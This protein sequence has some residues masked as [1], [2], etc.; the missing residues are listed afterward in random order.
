MELKW[1]L[2]VGAEAT[3]WT[4]LLAFL[5]LRYRYGLDRASIAVLVAILLDHVVILGLG[6]WD[7]AQ[8]GRVSAYSVAIVALLVYALTYG[9]CD[10]KR[11]DAWARRRVS[12]RRP[13]AGRPAARCAP[14]PRR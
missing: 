7:F 6:V 3:F 4:L 2:A 12:P 8:T 10:V 9:K 5:V 14:L 13:R 1:I 11:I